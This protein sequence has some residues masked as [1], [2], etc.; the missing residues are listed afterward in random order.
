MLV[1]DQ[2]VVAELVAQHEFVEILLVELVPLLGIEV[3]VG[4]IDPLALRAARHDIRVRHEVHQVELEPIE[5]RHRS[6]S[7]SLTN[8]IASYD[9]HRRKQDVRA[10]ISRAVRR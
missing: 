1:D 6:S 5:H 3:R 7:C 8:I 9:H 4:N 2:C 10:K